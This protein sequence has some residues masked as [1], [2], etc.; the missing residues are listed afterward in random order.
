MR[1]LQLLNV[2][3]KTMKITE[4]TVDKIAH[5]AR[6]EINSG[7]R[8]QMIVDMNRILDFMDKLNEVDTTN[9]E[10]LIYMT[11]EVNI[12][13]DDVVKQK[14]THEE[15]LEN[16]P[17]HDANYFLVPK[18]LEKKQHNNQPRTKS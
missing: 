1:Y 18:V 9:V 12:F 11:D 15:A 8:E 10:P 4:D 14:I 6:L 2:N 5:L 7:E 17:E 3:L 16:A 13:R